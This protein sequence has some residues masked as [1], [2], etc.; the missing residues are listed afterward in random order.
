MNFSRHVGH[1]NAIRDKILVVIQIWLWIQDLLKSVIRH[2]SDS[3]E[4]AVS[5]VCPLHVVNKFF[6]LMS[7]LPF[8]VSSHWS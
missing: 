6:F 8:Q 7:P 5:E 1:H 4:K 3:V 2:S